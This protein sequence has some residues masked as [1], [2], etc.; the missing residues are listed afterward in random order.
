[1]KIKHDNEERKKK[2][3]R[4]AHAFRAL[5]PAL[6]QRHLTAYNNATCSAALLNDDTPL[7][8]LADVAWPS[9]ADRAA[10]IALL[11]Y[12]NHYT[13]YEHNLITPRRYRLCGHLT[14]VS[15]RIAQR[16]A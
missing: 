14:D 4:Y 3:R 13:A 10:N 2:R 9:A 16:Y 11:L 8:C 15:Q 5:A 1:M 6:S 12:T 7:R